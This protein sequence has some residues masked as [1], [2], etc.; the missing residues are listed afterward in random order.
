MTTMLQCSFL[1]M[2]EVVVTMLSLIGQYKLFHECHFQLTAISR[3]LSLHSAQRGSA[4]IHIIQSM[5]GRDI[6]HR[7]F[8][9]R[10]INRTVNRS[11]FAVDMLAG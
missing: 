7:S 6:I 9:Y 11:Q 5:L 10:H 8:L 3:A 4:I 1:I 2:N